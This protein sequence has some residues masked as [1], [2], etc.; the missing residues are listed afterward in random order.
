VLFLLI[1][2]LPGAAQ[3]SVNQ[4]WPE[5]DTFFKVNSKLRLSFYAATTR[6]EAHGTDAEIGPNIDFFV[7][8][9]RKAKRFTIFQLDQ[10]KSRLLVLRSGYRY[11]PSTTAPTENRGILEAT[12]RYPIAWN[13]LV[14]DRNRTD[15]RFINQEFSWRYRNR[16]TAERE[17]AIKSYHLAPYV[18]AEAYYDSRYGKFSRT[19]ETAGCPFPIRKQSEIEP[20]YEHQNDTSKAPNR[21]VNAFGLVLNLYF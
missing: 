6:E 14:S 21:Q 1:Q 13:V 5:I 18:R 10:S 16:L 3:N 17:F 12:G 4:A 15:L 20:Y 7:K 9:L 19:S 11:M 2:V 8:P